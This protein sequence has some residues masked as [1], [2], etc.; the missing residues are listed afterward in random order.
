MKNAQ[1]PGLYQASRHDYRPDLTRMLNE[2]YALGATEDQLDRVERA[3]AEREETRE[4][5]FER[6]RPPTSS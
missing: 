1:T 6:P 2:V 4:R 5:V 3:L